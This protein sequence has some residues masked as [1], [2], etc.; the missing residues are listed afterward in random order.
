MC[1]KKF[2]HISSGKSPHPPPPVGLCL[3][4]FLMPI[5]FFLGVEQKKNLE[6]RSKW[7]NFQNVLSTVQELAMTV[8]KKLF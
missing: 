6:I 4:K 7:S 5:N 8:C 1:P 2:Q 3:P